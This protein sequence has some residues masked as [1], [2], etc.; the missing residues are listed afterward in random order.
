MASGLECK[1][2]PVPLALIFLRSDDIIDGEIVFGIFTLGLQNSNVVSY[3]SHSTEF[4]CRLETQILYYYR[5][6]QKRL[7][8]PRTKTTKQ[9]QH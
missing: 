7:I 2:E 4:G 9:F 3:V 8:A 5:A 1:G 6:P